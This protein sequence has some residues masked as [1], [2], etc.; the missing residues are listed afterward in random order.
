MHGTEHSHGSICGQGGV[1]GSC[2]QRGV[3]RGGGVS[4]AFASQVYKCQASVCGRQ[5]VVFVVVVG[6]V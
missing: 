6:S 1:R 3:V 2:L 5:G 4:W